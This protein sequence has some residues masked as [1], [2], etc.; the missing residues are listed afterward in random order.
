MPFA[1]LRALALAA[2][3]LALAP[4]AGAQPAGAPPDLLFQGFHWNA[5][6]GDLGS[7]FFGV[8]WDSLATVAPDLAALGVQT[9]WIPSPAK[10]GGG[11]YSMGYD[12]YDYYDLG[13]NFQKGGTR[14]RFGKRSQLDA[15]LAG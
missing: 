13:T 14:T 15:M 1:P 9:V 11:R 2:L 12:L 4:R 6:P 3:C 8:W 10:G 5:H 7:P